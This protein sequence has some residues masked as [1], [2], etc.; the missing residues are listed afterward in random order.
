MAIHTPDLIEI[1]R[2]QQHSP[3]ATEIAPVADGNGARG[4]A[5]YRVLRLYGHGSVQEQSGNL[6]KRIGGGLKRYVSADSLGRQNRFHSQIVDAG[7]CCY[8]PW[9]L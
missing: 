8:R 9:A 3:Y 4:E 7:V 2:A 5:L 1:Q 6:R